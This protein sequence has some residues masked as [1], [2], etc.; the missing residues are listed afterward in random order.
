MGKLGELRNVLSGMGKE[1]LQEKTAKADDKD[2]VVYAAALAT[3][4][5]LIMEEQFWKIRHPGE[6]YP[7]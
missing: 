7:G 5:L 4:F 2:A 6:E 1:E 3:G